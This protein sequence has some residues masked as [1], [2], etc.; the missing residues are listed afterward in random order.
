MARDAQ[1]AAKAHDPD[2]RFMAMEAQMLLFTD[3]VMREGQGQASLQPLLAIAR[4]LSLVQGRK[5]LLYFSE[6]LAVP[7]AVEDLFQTTVSTANRSNVSVYAFDARG[8]RVRSPSEETKLALDLA[9]DTALSDQVGGAMPDE[10]V[11]TMAIDPLEMSQDALRLNRQGVL[12][13]SPRARAASSWRRRTTCGP[14]LE[15]VMADLRAYYE[16]G[17]VPPNPK[18]DGR[19]RTISVKVSRPGVVVRTRRGYY[20]MPPGAPVVLP[21]EMALAEALAATPMPRDVEH[22]AA[23]LRFAGGGPETETLVWVEVPLAGLTLTRGETDLPRPREPARPGE[24]REGD[25][26]RASQPRRA[27]RGP[28]RRGRSGA[29]A[30]DRGEADAAPPAGAIRARDG[31]PGPRERP[32]RRAAH[33]VRDPDARP[34]AEPGQRRDRAR[35]RGGCCRARHERPAP[36]GPAARD[37]APRSVVSR[38]NTSRLAAAEPLRRARGRSARG[39]ARVPE[40]RAGGRARDAGAARARTRAGGSRTSAASRPGAST[41]AATRSGHAVGWETSKPPRRRRSRSRRGPRLPSRRIRGELPARRRPR[42]PSA[43]ARS[44]TGRASRRR[45]RRSSSGPAA[46]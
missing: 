27:D 19:W 39:R 13:T 18:A 12:G 1:A 7:P 32:R 10:A 23:T 42:R 2:W 28:A 5:S 6:G 29:P 14:G 3:S 34:G 11:P 33:R 37:A 31:G 16:V 44:R 40:G 30:D 24:G 43:P 22:R 15:R 41:R 46:M 17:Y 35:R 36:G 26:R 4:G 25:A 8:L 45:S 21:Y 38:G 9:R 20:A